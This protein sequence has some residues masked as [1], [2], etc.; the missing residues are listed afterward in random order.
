MRAVDG[1]PVLFEVLVDGQSKYR[2]EVKKRRIVS[3]LE[4][5]MEMLQDAPPTPDLLKRG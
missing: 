4:R 5:Q 2:S 3:Y 1:A